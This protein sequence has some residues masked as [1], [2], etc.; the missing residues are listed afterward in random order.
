MALAAQRIMLGELDV[1]VAGGVESMS[2]V[3]MGGYKPMPNPELMA[4]YPQ[5][6][7]GMG[8]TAEEVARRFD[9][10]RADQDAFAL[11][12]HQKAAAARDAGRFRDEI[13]PV[14]V[15]RVRL[16]GGRPVAEDGH[17]AVDEGIRD[18]T[19][20]EKLAAL[21]PAITSPNAAPRPA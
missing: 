21:K 1:A 20:A 13:V 6:Y 18:D 19:T 4:S 2:R 15:R 3:P 17:F 8:H 7:M 14:P 9:V 11:T 5:V 10:S 12:S 16:A